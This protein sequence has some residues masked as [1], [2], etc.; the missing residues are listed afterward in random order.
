MLQSD[1]NGKP[2]RAGSVAANAGDLSRDAEA[3]RTSELQQRLISQV[4]TAFSFA[5]QIGP[6]RSIKLEWSTDGVEDVLGFSES[7]IRGLVSFRSRI[8]PD[9]RKQHQATLDRVL[10]GQ[11]QTVEFRFL[12]KSG[13]QCW[14]QSLSQPEWSPAENRVIRIVGATQDITDRKRTE[15]ELRNE[16]ERLK[17]ALDVAC[18]GEWEW[19]FATNKVRSNER[20]I[21][22]F[23]GPEAKALSEELEFRN[24]IHPEDTPAVENAIQSAINGD[25]HYHANFRVIWL[26]GSIHWLEGRGS[27][28]RNAEGRPLRMVGVTVDI[29]DRRNN[30]RR[31]QTY[32]TLAHA[33]NK[34]DTVQ[35]ASRWIT[36]VAD[37]LIGWDAAVMI[38]FNVDT[39]LCRSVMNVDLMDGVK[40]NVLSAFNDKPPS[41][42]MRKTIEQGAELILRSTPSE[43]G[44]ELS[45]FG[46]TTRRSAS[47]MF[48]P[49]RDGKTTVGMLSIQSYRQNAYTPDDLA[50]LQSLADECAA[51][52]ARIRSRKIQKETQER[53]R[54][55]LENT[56]NVCVQWFDDQGRVLYWNPASESVFGWKSAEAIG[57]TLDQLILNDARTKWFLDQIKTI[58][59]GGRFI[60]PVEFEFKRRNG[61]MGVCLSTLF[62]I[63]APEGG[64]HFVCMAVDITARK[65]SEVENARITS[66]LHATVESSADG[67]LVV[68]L[69]NKVTLYNQ[70]FAELWHIPKELLA[71]NDDAALLNFVPT[72]LADPETFLNGVRELYARPDAESFDTLLFKDGRSFERYSHPQKIGDQII[73]RVWNFRDVT[74]R[75][76]LESSLRLTQFSVDRAADAVFWVAPDSK[77]LYVNDAACRTLGW[78]REEMVGRTVPEIDVNFPASAWPAHWEELRQR[79]SFTFESGHLKKDGSSIMTELTVNYIE[80][81]GREYNCAIMRD[82]TARKQAEEALQMMRFSVDHAGDSV[83]WISREGRILYANDVGWASR[84]Y[85]REELLGMTVFDLDPDFQPEVWKPHWQDLKQRGTITLETRHRAKDGRL[86]P[87][88]VTANYVSI[89]GQEFNF[90]SLRDITARKQAES[91]L[92]ASEQQF[93]ALVNNIDGIVWE[94]D[95]ETMSLTFVSFQAERILGYP[96]K[97]WLENKNFWRDHIHPDDRNQAVDYSLIQT[98]LGQSHDFEYRMIAADGRIVWMR[99]L[100]VVTLKDGKPVGLHGIMV[101]ITKQKQS[102]LV[103]AESTQRLQLISRQLIELQEA[104][105]RHLA[106]ELHDEVGQTLTATK[107]ILEGIK[108]QT[109][110]VPLAGAMQK[111][112]AADSTP[113]L[114]NA[115]NHVD[116]LLKIV[117]NL[118]LNLR[119]PMLD[120]F[121]LVS[122]LRW[123][124]DQHNKN[125][126]RIVELDAEY[127]VE[128]P[129]STIET[130]CFRTAQEALTNVTRYSNAKKVSVHLHTDADGIHLVVKDDGIGFNVTAALS[131]A[132]KGG[133]LGLINMQERAGI[134]GGHM[135]I[136]SAPGKGT[137]IRA[138]FPLAMQPVNITS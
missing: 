78:S 44:D 47:L 63:P 72:Q 111:S 53:L 113:L 114:T 24:F 64:R 27:V 132:R 54:A 99:D 123:L 100:V 33:L 15:D 45:T 46:D 40:Q 85:T 14:L 43:S 135:E 9:D 32:A 61:N 6:D 35:E 137:E 92:R 121:G 1:D 57:K 5:Y 105:R 86:F 98:Q 21:A 94:V 4:I 134:V 75:K 136:I 69:D 88:E 34:A 20:L 77:I 115:V 127:E 68:D 8:H 22:M 124:L 58:N 51:A 28:F 131:H 76:R 36:N 52:L 19:D 67:L 70:R 107:I 31:I 59:V 93:A 97:A 23:G 120:D 112:T 55:S 11:Q 133:S 108:H 82:I 41:A 62:A 3:L 110:P 12:T 81:E 39:G 29:T 7:E 83:F 84:G 50:A 42:R 30:E 101:D 26:D 87:V 48:V 80:F 74:E 122:A 37:E 138:R 60:G 10:A 38:L 103:A 130:A 16:S 18:L 73:G 104:E 89:G 118:S 13:E 119:P 17:L 65:E 128:H 96:P 116:H 66:L 49:V 117:R 109:A 91:A 71:L 2:E 56:P 90:A 102:E 106:R 126:G 95:V 129:D 79:K 25:D 125:T